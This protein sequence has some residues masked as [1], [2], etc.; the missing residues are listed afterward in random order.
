MKSKHLSGM[1]WAPGL[2]FAKQTEKSCRQGPRTLALSLQEPLGRSQ[3]LSGASEEGP[4]IQRQGGARS[5]GDLAWQGG[6]GLSPQ[7][8]ALAAPHFMHIREKSKR[9]GPRLFH[10]FTAFVRAYFWQGSSQ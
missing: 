7:Q 10:L 3:G 5:T 8:A 2:L 1:L 4:G 9:D 6:S